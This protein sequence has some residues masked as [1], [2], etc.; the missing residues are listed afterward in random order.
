MIVSILQ[1]SN[2]VTKEEVLKSWDSSTAMVI[3]DA[4][5]G[6]LKKNDKG[7]IGKLIKFA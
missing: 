4:I 7:L 6:A 2:G 1:I 5:P 3:A